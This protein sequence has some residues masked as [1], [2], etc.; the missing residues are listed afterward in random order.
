MMTKTKFSMATGIFEISLQNWVLEILVK[1]DILW[2]KPVKQV[3]VLVLKGDKQ[4]I[5]GIYCSAHVC[6]LLYVIMFK[7]VW[8]FFESD[9][10]KYRITT[11]PYFWIV[12]LISGMEAIILDIGDIKCMQSPKCFYKVFIFP[13]LT[14]IQ[15]SEHH[16]IANSISECWNRSH[17]SWFHIITSL[18]FHL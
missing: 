4:A 12:K 13:P 6:R 1:W 17:V 11:Q 3:H 18:F 5:E 16:I 14:H 2:G 7:F 9:F 10:L 15:N 8:I